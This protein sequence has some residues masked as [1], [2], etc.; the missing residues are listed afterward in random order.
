MLLR[1]WWSGWEARLVSLT[2]LALLA[3]ILA[4]QVA[5]PASLITLLNLLSYAAGGFFGVRAA[6]EQL[7]QRQID[8]DSADV[9]RRHRSGQHR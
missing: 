2:L 5:A 4:E 8:V 7:R 1:W 6:A 3:S 9:D